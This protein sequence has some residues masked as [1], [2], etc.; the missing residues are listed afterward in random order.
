MGMAQKDMDNYHYP[1]GGK[2]SFQNHNLITIQSAN[3]PHL[4][5]LFLFSPQQQWHCAVNI[6]E[7][8]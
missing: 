2:K 3:R 7:K 5:L 4:K 8:I 1:G 6:K